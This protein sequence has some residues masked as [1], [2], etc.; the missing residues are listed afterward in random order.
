MSIEKW[1]AF[2]NHSE[3]VTVVKGTFR[4]TPKLLIHDQCNDQMWQAL[5]YARQVSKDDCRLADTPEAALV[6]L[7]RREEHKL[8]KAAD[9]VKVAKEKLALVAAKQAEQ[10]EYALA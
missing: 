6:A 4:E 10:A 8:E 5:S 9:Q 3:G 7:F 2:L 1:S